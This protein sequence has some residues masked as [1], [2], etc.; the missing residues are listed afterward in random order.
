MT[1][2]ALT[3]DVTLC[4]DMSSFHLS[5]LLCCSQL[6]G[7]SNTQ[8]HLLNQVTHILYFSYLQ[9]LQVAQAALSGR[10]FQPKDRQTDAPPMHYTIGEMPC[11]TLTSST[12]IPPA[13]IILTVSHSFASLCHIC[14]T[15]ILPLATSHFSAWH[16]CTYHVSQ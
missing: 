2:Y 5:C 10:L 16:C 3:C 11:V 14:L 8:I 13:P 9:V 7:I 15:L 6:Q 1:Y 12:H 4:H